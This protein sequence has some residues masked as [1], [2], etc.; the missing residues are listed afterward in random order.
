M[1]TEFDDL[2]S[3]AVVDNLETARAYYR[4][5][6]FKELL[7]ASPFDGIDL[8]RTREFPRDIEF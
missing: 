1:K 2:V 3:K 8:T 6:D 4:S 5:L 7:V